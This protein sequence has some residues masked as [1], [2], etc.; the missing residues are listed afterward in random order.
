[1][2]MNTGIYSLAEKDG[3]KLKIY[4]RTDE[5]TGL[6]VAWWCA[7]LE[8]KDPMEKK[9]IEVVSKII[10][11]WN[12]WTGGRHVVSLFLF[13]F[14]YHDCTWCGLG[15]RVLIGFQLRSV[16][17]S[18]SWYKGADVIK[19]MIR[20]T[21]FMDVDCTTGVKADD[22]NGLHSVTG[23]C[24]DL[25]VIPWYKSVNI[26]STTYRLWG[27]YCVLKQ[28]NFAPL[29]D[30]IRHTDEVL[31]SKMEIGKV[32][33]QHKTCFQNYCC[34]SIT[35]EQTRLAWK[36]SAHH[37]FPLHSVIWTKPRHKP[38]KFKREA[39]HWREVCN[40]FLRGWQREM[41]KGVKRTSR[42]WKTICRLDIEIATWWGSYR[43][44]Q[45]PS[46]N[47]FLYDIR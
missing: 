45:N 12:R 42:T 35:V 43:P 15:S 23:W 24:C 27:K 2:I 36:C 10:R 20:L 40:S 25:C 19:V 32:L 16:V 14:F 3:K 37:E 13:F 26:I 34:S 8:V 9:K 31:C 33:K 5:V 6:K 4:H 44:D 28:Q 29:V 39:K 22:H 21:R 11:E 17:N 30:R 46:L 38:E 47:F 7:C 41:W 18:R 1:M